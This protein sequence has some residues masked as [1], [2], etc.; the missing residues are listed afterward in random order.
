M[1]VLHLPMRG[2]AHMSGGMISMGQLDGLIMMFN[3][4]FFKGL[5][6]F[7]AEGRLRSKKNKVKKSA[8]KNA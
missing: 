8:V 3:G 5:G 7:F 6:K 4:H 1:G 2:L